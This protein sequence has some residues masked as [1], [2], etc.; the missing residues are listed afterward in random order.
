MS[1]TGETIPLPPGQTV[2]GR[3]EFQAAGLDDKR[4]SRRH[5]QFDFTPSTGGL[6]LTV[7]CAHKI[8]V[9]HFSSF[10]P[11]IHLRLYTKLDR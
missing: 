2:L 3:T 5:C 7:V 11:V 6:A 9:V 8:D 1:E 4:I 10:G